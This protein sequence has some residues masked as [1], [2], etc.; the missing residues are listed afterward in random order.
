MTIES[1]N[2]RTRVPLV[3]VKRGRVA[4]AGA[5]GGTAGGSVL[6]EGG[7]EGGASSASV[8]GAC[9]GSATT[10]GVGGVAAGLAAT[11]DGAG[12]AHADAVNAPSHASVSA[13][14]VLTLN[15]RADD[16]MPPPVSSIR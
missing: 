1:P 4:A 6:G 16:T 13:M 7:G 9:T 14:R 10:L 5:W 8:P 15:P 3:T 12:G 2:I 11:R